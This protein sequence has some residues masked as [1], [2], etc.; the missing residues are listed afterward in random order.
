M[1]KRRGYSDS[2]MQAWW[3][4]AVLAVWG[5]GC[6]HCGSPEAH[7]HHVVPRAR[8]VLRN[9]WRN[10]IPLCA[11]CHRWAHTLEGRR[12]VESQVDTEYLEARD[13][14]LKEY[15][16]TS[17]ITREEFDRKQLGELKSIASGEPES[18]LL[19]RR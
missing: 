4:Q 5:T 14:N 7:C 11:E 15:L 16:F 3:R 18:R 2:H 17:G 10:G 6:A 8:R 1:A 12:W 9:D 19:L 13:T